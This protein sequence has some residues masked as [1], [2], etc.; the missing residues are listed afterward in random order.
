M[1][2]RLGYG[3]GNPS[4]LAACQQEVP[5]FVVVSLAGDDEPGHVWPSMPA[6]WSV[7]STRRLARAAPAGQ[8][9]EKI[10][11]RVIPGCSPEHGAPAR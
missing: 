7:P 10:L 1:T 6:D 4:L 11:S 9:N 3:G 5:V 2:T 8:P